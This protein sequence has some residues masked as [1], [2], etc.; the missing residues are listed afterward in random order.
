MKGFQLSRYGYNMIERLQDAV[1]RTLN[2][3]IP[4]DIQYAVNSYL[5]FN[6]NKNER[7]HVCFLFFFRTLIISRN[8]SISPTI[9][10]NSAACPTISKS[11]DRRVFIS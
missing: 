11:S 9:L 7:N 6:F 4:L 5:D 2:A 10:T 8:N 3:N 1:N